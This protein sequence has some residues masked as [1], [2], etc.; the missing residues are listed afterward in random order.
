MWLVRKAKDIT[1]IPPAMEQGYEWFTIMDT[2]TRTVT[3][4]TRA[5]ISDLYRELGAVL[6]DD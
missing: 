6:N 3:W 4:K 2:N 1:P 5:E